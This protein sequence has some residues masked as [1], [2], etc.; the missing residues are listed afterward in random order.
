MVVSSMNM[1]KALFW[2]TLVTVTPL[3]QLMCA[4]A[5]DNHAASTDTPEFER[6]SHGGRLLTSGHLSLELS[7]FEEGVPPHY[8]VYPTWKGEP[9]APKDVELTI[10][11]T[12]LG[13]RVDTVKF[14]AVDAFLE[15]IPSI[16]EPHSFDIQVTARHNG[17]E[18][19]W[20]F[21]SYEGRTTLPADT[22]QAS[23]VRTDVAGAHVI[24]KTL[25]VRGK[26]LPSEHHIAHI[27]PRFSGVVR[28]GRKH[29]GDPVQKGEVLAVIESNQSLQPFE[30]RSQISGTVINGHLIVGEF[31]PENQ[32]VYIVADLSEV[33]A[34]FFVPVS[35]RDTVHMGQA[36]SLSTLN[37]HGEA[38]HT[39]SAT[40]SYIAPYVDEKTQT[41]LVRAVVQNQD[42][43]LLP[44]TFITGE[45]VVDESSAP[46]AVR[47][48]AL[49][50]WR[51][52]DAVFIKVGDTYEVRPVTLGERDKEWVAI[53]AGLPAGATYVTENSFLI[54][55]DIL[56]AGA[57][58]DH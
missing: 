21:S 39:I 44:G 33:W 32:W 18:F 51:E 34:D 5:S 17:E 8:R 6:G 24:R 31:V 9:L 36:L 38:P 58:H 1:W 4:W 20:S 22:A 40:V 15:S 37:P 42:R 12:R 26:V 19:S 46:V 52:E 30:V 50:R 55:A 47:K 56:K 3:P 54:K 41:V 2:G 25:P 35:E 49:Q 23:G 7:M 45:L 11:L 29:I 14:R 43:A 13:G 28:E 57:S 48:S 53:T 10:T 16:D 27:I